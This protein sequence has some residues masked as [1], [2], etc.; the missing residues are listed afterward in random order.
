MYLLK[1]HEGKE[2]FGMKS[3]LH[4]IRHHLNTQEGGKSPFPAKFRT[5]LE[6]VELDT[7]QGNSEARL[8]MAKNISCLPSPLQV[9]QQ[10]ARA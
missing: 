10:I 7:A 8:A 2:S 6:T 4:G 3:S 5:E 1:C 9:L